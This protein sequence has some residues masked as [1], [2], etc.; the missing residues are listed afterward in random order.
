MQVYI[1]TNQSGYVKCVVT[2]AKY[3]GICVLWKVRRVEERV[4]QVVQG[5]HLN[6]LRLHQR[7]QVNLDYV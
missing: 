4:Q 3:N 2:W 6:Q 7:I 5:C 1:I